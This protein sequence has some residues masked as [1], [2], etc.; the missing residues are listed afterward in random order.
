MNKKNI[1]AV[2]FLLIISVLLIAVIFGNKN[3]TKKI[4]EGEPAQKLKI[5]TTIFP[6]YDIAK[7]IVGDGAE[8]SLLLNP[9]I[10]AHSF[11]PTPSD[12]IKISQADIFIYTGKFMETWAEDIIRSVNNP[13]LLVIDASHNINLIAGEHDENEFH[14]GSE[15]DRHKEGV[16]PHIWL[17][18]DNL[19]TMVNNINDGL[20]TKAVNNQEDFELRAANYI[21]EI[22]LLDKKYRETLN[23]CQQKSIIYSGHYAFA[24]LAKRYN[25]GYSSAYG[26]SPNAEPSAST[27]ISLTKQL[28]ANNSKY[29]FHEELLS[30]RLAETL[31]RETGAKLLSLN[32]AHNLSRQELDENK[33]LFMVFE[34]NLHKLKLG[35]NC[36]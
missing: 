20:K 32:A 21:D 29:I 5:I 15:S 22:S 31:E 6:L 27:L 12:M 13:D 7:N 1:I 33:T 28:K 24:Y 16:D 14:E 18:F 36:R 19:K 11:E 35:L 9:G 8:I 4:N 26:L 2:I 3:K 34:D 10:E 25:L 23:N 30:P 17:D